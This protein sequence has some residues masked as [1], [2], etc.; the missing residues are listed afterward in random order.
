MSSFS[1]I[2]FPREVDTSI[3]KS[4]FDKS[5]TRTV[6]EI[7]GTELGRQYENLPDDMNV[8][9]GDWNDFHGLQIFDRGDVSFNSVF[10]NKYIYGL[11]A[12]FKLLDAEEFLSAS[13]KIYETTND[14]PEYSE[15]EHMAFSQGMIKDNKDN[16]TIC[17]QQLYDIVQ[18]NIK[19]GE[20]VEIYTDWVDSR[21]IFNFGPPAEIKEMDIKQ[22]STS[23]LLD[24][25]ENVMLEIRRTI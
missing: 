11:Q 6:G 13:K 24:L 15:D 2:A 16:V 20:V 18:H 14:N 8:Y 19:I 12:V 7:R 3:L 25:Q 5:K 21:N 23:E 10:T 17:R 22:I 9:L 1:Y 4:K